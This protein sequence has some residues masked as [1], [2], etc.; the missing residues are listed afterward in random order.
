MIF[1]KKIKKLI[2]HPN[3]YFYDYFRKKLGFRK[4]FVT[5]KIRLLDAG[6]HQKWHKVLFS[7]PHLYLYYKF[8]KKLRKPA[9]P[10]LVDYRIDFIDKNYMGGGKAEVLAVEL[11][12]KN[13]IYFYNPEIISKVRSNKEPNLSRIILKFHFQGT[14][15]EI[16]LGTKAILGRDLNINFKGNQNTL[17]ICQNCTINSGSNLNFD[18]D[19]CIA[20]FGPDTNGQLTIRFMGNNSLSY[21]CGKVRFAR[22]VILLG[23]D[24]I[25]FI[26]RGCTFG[27]NDQCH[28]RETKNIIIGTDC[29]FSWN[30]LLRNGAGHAIYDKNTKS[31]ISK[32]ESIIIGDHVWINMD[33]KIFKDVQ[34]ESGSIIGAESFLSGTKVS[35][36]CI[37][38]GA[39][40]KVVREE[41]L[42]TRGGPGNARFDALTS[43][44]NYKE[45]KIKISQIGFDKLSSIDQIPPSMDA[46]DK[47]RAITEILKDLID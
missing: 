15:N 17:M 12:H 36:N 8:N 47:I 4:Y 2:L 30:V 21:V 9:Y 33:S 39:P 22:T 7:H 19:N 45:P 29:M 6:N 5:D 31:R 16:H 43:F 35:Q 34:I 32:A 14:G 1:I 25:L 44:D 38:A 28:L 42:W 37:V 10:I 20:Y 27:G 41:V 24:S 13:I 26:G 40:A 3:I 46:K 18:K 11:E 23:S